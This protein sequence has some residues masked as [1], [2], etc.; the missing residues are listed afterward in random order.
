MMKNAEIAN[1]FCEQVQ[2]KTPVNAT[3][4]LPGQTL[5]QECK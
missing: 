3:D 2:M 4:M 5:V 1:T